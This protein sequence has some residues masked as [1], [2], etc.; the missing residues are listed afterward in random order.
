MLAFLAPPLFSTVPPT[1]TVKKRGEGITFNCG[2]TGDPKPIVS[3]RRVSS[4]L[5]EINYRQNKA[6]Q[7]SFNIIQVNGGLSE[8]VKFEGE[9][10]LHITNIQPEDHGCYEC[11]VQNTIA[12]LS[13]QACLYVN[14]K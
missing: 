1:K 2:A 8:R 4:V 3:W 13:K 12:I 14:S 6:M 7:K 9:Q 11:V 5:S 10:N